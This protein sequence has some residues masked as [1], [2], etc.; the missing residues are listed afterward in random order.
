MN[1]ARFLS[2][3]LRSGFVGSLV[4]GSLGTVLSRLQGSL[5]AV[6]GL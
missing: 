5:V 2:S 3:R 6:A 1:T 4:S